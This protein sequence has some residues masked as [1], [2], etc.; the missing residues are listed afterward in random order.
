PS[1]EFPR[2][3]SS[4]Y[5]ENLIVSGIGPD[6]TATSALNFLVS[7]PFLISCR[8]K[9]LGFRFA[10]GRRQEFFERDRSS[11]N[12]FVPLQAAS[13]SL[14]R[15]Q[16]QCRMSFLHSG[17]G[18]TW[19]RHGETQFGAGRITDWT[20]SGLRDLHVL[21]T[22]F[23]LSSCPNRATHRPGRRSGQGWLRRS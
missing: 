20:A 4:E 13:G 5:S 19:N 6:S 18:L 11:S 23:D 21:G 2:N 12:H 14:K 15:P 3:L 8:K 22:S 17:I 7:D 9:W 16:A 10:F 1:L